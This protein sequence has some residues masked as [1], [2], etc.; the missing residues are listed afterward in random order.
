MTKI[1]VSTMV[2]NA[3]EWYD[4]A[5]YAQFATIIGIHFF[6]KSELTEILTFAVFAAG[7]IVRPLGAVV[8]G[9]IGDK[10]GRKFALTLGMITMAI[11][12][13]AIGFLPSYETIGIAAPILLTVIRLIQGFSLGG[14]FSGC[15]SY[16]VESS[17]M[18]HRGLA[19][20]SAFFSMCIGMLFG[21][22]TAEFCK[23]VMSEEFLVSFGW[24]IPFVMGL[25]IGLIG[26]Y[27]R[28]R[29]HESPLYLKAKEN[30]N[31]SKTPVFD[32]VKHHKKT[33]L[34]AIGLYLSV[35]VPF[36]ITTVYLSSFVEH[37]GFSSSCAS[38]SNIAVLISMATSIIIS[39]IIS[40][41]IGRKPVMIIAC[42]MFLFSSYPLFWVMSHT[43]DSDVIIIASA[44]LAA[45]NGFFMGPIPTVLVELFPTKIRFTGVALSYNLSAAIFGGTSPMFI[46]ILIKEFG[47][48]SVI[49]YC[50]C[51]FVCISLAT[52]IFYRETYKNLLNEST[53]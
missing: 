14:E 32:L 27:I 38:L 51:N 31:L 10:V 34:V 44:I 28:T 18:K 49:P 25:F 17:E 13:A 46:M 6:P 23:V 50:L 7:F 26:L 21:S 20:S 39:A 33:M 5:L 30:G 19:G 22:F 12:T 53:E 40:D 3:L 48:T 41:K 35:T 42:M 47:D 16:V 37:L 24:R 1:L 9:N 8:F 45:I 4:Y 52:L 36:Y 15:I 29:L 43:K 2:G 11:P